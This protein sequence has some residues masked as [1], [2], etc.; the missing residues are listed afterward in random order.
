MSSLFLECGCRLDEHLRDVSGFR[1]RPETDLGNSQGL[2]EPWVLRSQAVNL[3]PESC[4]KGTGD[5]HRGSSG[6]QDGRT[7]R[8]D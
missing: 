3:A 6:Q 4:R 1:H 7:P 2:L 5:P 8:A